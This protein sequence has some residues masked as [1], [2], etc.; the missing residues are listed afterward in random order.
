MD[1]IEIAKLILNDSRL[2]VE[3]I[4]PLILFGSAIYK[5]NSNSLDLLLSDNRIQVPT[6]WENYDV[7]YYLKDIPS[8]HS[9]NDSFM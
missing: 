1:S 3:N 8:F 5:N 6:N 4:D 9:F 7:K 2:D